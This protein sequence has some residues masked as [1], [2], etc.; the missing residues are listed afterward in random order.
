M[1]YHEVPCKIGSI[2]RCV[3]L[4]VTMDFPNALFQKFVA[5]LAEKAERKLPV[6]CFLL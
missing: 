5:S 3:A 2:R 1:K 6:F 4:L